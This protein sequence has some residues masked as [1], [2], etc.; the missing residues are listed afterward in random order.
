[1]MQLNAANAR[2][3]VTE[4]ILLSRAEDA[5]QKIGNISGRLK[6]IQRIISATRGYWTGEAGD[7]CRQWYEG[8]KQDIDVLL[9]RLEAQPGMLLKIANVYKTTEGAAR[10]INVPLPENFIEW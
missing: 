3:C 9:K 8:G 7:A 2:I 5:Q 10:N 1:M 6:K 4:D